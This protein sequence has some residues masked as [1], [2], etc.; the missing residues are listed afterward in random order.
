[1]LSTAPGLNS[2]PHFMLQF[3]E[4]ATFHLAG[5]RVGTYQTNTLSVQPHD[6]RNRSR[7]VTARDLNCPKR[8]S[9]PSGAPVVRIHNF[10]LRGMSTFKGHQS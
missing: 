2:G 9:L 6:G 10:E 1:V 4:L 3:L 5:F 8:V 7:G